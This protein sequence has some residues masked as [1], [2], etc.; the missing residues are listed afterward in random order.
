MIEKFI[1]KPLRETGDNDW[2]HFYGHND[3]SQAD[4]ICICTHQISDLCRITY[5]PL[6]ID[7]LVGNVCIGKI[8][9]ALRDMD[10][11]QN[12]LQN[13]IIKKIK[14]FH[15]ESK[16]KKLQEQWMKRRVMRKL[17][18]FSK[19]SKIEK[20]LIHRLK[21]IK[22][23]LKLF[24]NIDEWSILFGK[25]KGTKYKVLIKNNPQYCTWMYDNCEN[26]KLEIREY[27]RCNIDL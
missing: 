2:T 15:R 22:E 21:K 12:K 6:D 7:F 27:L 23:R 1:G 25:H 24:K 4:K 9:E 16:I 18:K 26:L 17:K 8:S 5:I 11:K 10:K 20:H 19:L 13:K 14:A 3:L